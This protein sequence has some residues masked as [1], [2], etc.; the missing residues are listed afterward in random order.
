MYRDVQVVIWG[1]GSKGVTFL[2]LVRADD[3]VEYAVDVNPYKQD[4]FVAG[5]GQEIGAPAFLRQYRPDYVILMNDVYK[6]EIGQT[7]KSLGIRPEIILV[8]TQ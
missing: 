8:Q 2:N 5:T 4:K 3:A 1:A 7:L 6:A